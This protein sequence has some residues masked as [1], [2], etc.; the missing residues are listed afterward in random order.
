MN[1]VY[2]T[3]GQKQIE[4]LFGNEE[5]ILF[6]DAFHLEHLVVSLGVF[7]SLTEARKNNWSGDIPRGFK[8]H[9]IGKRRFWTY[10]P[11]LVTEMFSRE[12]L[13]NLVL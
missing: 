2:F 11:V 9:K 7:R 12:F 8:E 13:E 6:D 3:V 10:R 1:F 5:V 4:C